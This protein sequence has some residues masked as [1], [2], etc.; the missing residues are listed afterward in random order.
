MLS[1]LLMTPV[2]HEWL[3]TLG[4]NDTRNKCAINITWLWPPLKEDDVF[5][6][7]LVGL[8]TEQ[9]TLQV[10]GRESHPHFP[11]RGMLVDNF[12]GVL[13]NGQKKEKHLRTRWSHIS[14]F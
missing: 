1:V 4:K 7:I 11:R 8:L 14:H 10:N 5:Q 9:S 13:G 12:V 3:F 2:C 6:N